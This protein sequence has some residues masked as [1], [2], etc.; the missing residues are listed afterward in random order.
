MQ[1]VASGFVATE[2]LL[3]EHSFYDPRELLRW[4][5]TT[6]RRGKLLMKRSTRCGRS[7]IAWNWKQA[8][9]RPP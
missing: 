6:A 8:S 4:P 2:G 9:P 3:G 7:A 5:A 1:K